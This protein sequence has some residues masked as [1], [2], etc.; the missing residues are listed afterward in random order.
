ML[1]YE[2]PRCFGISRAWTGVR[3]LLRIR[4]DRLSMF[5]IIFLKV[6]HFNRK[7]LNKTDS[8]ENK[9]VMRIDISIIAIVSTDSTKRN[10]WKD[11]SHIDKLLNYKD[12][13]KEPNVPFVVYADFECIFENNTRM[14]TGS[15]K[16]INHQVSSTH[17]VRIYIWNC[18]T[19]TRDQKAGEWCTTQ[20][21]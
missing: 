18:R 5:V 17:T 19:F 12:I 16:I 1:T 20:W 4:C 7:T 15:R 2:N 21:S 9:P 8:W 11:I 3:R 10:S 6:I 13:S 14:P